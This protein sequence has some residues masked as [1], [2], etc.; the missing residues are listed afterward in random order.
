VITPQSDNDN[1]FLISANDTQFL[2]KEEAKL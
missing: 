1:R 2:A